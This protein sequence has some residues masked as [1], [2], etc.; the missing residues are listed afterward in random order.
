MP[1]LF[2][3]TIL[4]EVRALLARAADTLRRLPARPPDPHAL[5]EAQAAVQQ[6]QAALAA[7]PA[8]PPALG[9]DLPPLCTVCG[10]PESGHPDT[11][12]FH[13]FT[14]AEPPAEP[15]EDPPEHKPP[16]PV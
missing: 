8:T 10:Q 14:P 9:V 11:E 7:L 6:A 13:R 2:D 1:P 16:A 4:A 3:L 15:P 12:G 5:A